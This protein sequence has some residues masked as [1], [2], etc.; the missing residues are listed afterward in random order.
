MEL[1]E[2]K[3][4]CESGVCK[5]AVSLYQAEIRYPRKLAEEQ[6]WFRE[7]AEILIEEGRIRFSLFWQLKDERKN[8]Q[9]LYLTEF[10]WRKAIQEGEL[11][12][13]PEEAFTFVLSEPRVLVDGEGI[14]ALQAES[15]ECISRAQCR[16]LNI[17]IWKGEN[18]DGT[19]G[20]F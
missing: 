14:L 2:I 5:C 6:E 19:R 4:W 16:E 8:T 7:M 12:I 20:E 9:V 3:T 15:G 17:H 13:L 18:R 10:G 11:V 1:K